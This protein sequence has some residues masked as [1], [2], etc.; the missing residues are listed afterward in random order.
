MDPDANQYTLRI[1]DTLVGTVSY[2]ETLEPRTTIWFEDNA[3]STNY[4]NAYYDDF[5]VMGVLPVIFGDFDG[6]GDVNFSDFAFLAD[7]WMNEYC[8]ESD[9][10]MGTDLIKD[11]TVDWHDVT[12]FAEVWLAQIGDL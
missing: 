1:N 12:E 3:S 2:L 6:D 8:V 7:Y 9:W 10:C 4:L 5:L 11:G